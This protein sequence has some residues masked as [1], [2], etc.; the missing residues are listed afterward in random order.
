MRKTIGRNQR[1]KAER[2]F[3]NAE[4]IRAYTL[5]NEFTGKACKREDY[6]GENWLLREWNM[7]SFAKL[8]HQTTNNG[9]S[10]YCLYVHSNCWYDF[11][12]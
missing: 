3:A 8:T 5:D 9:D 6:Q 10:K 7:F 11:T 12:N 4:N 2:I 1:K